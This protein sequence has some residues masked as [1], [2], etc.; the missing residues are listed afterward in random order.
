MAEPSVS[1]VIPVYKNAGTVRELSSRLRS[2]LEGAG[3]TDYEVLFVDDAGPDDSLSV[4]DSL[5]AE[6]PRISVIVLAQNVG[7]QRAVLEG[8]KLALG[9]KAVVLDA[10]LQDAPEA[11]PVL[12]AGLDEGVEAVF[13]G[14]RGAYESRLR[15]LTSKIF[16]RLLGYITGVPA[17][18]GIF[19]AVSRR[20]IDALLEFDE[21]RPFVVALIGRT[22]MPSISIPVERTKRPGGESA[23]SSWARIKI[24]CRA[25]SRAL[26]WK[27][28]ERF[29]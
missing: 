13:A 10:D 1:I 2:T 14:R 22:K 9:S 17:D 27:W 4:L 18:A 26:A 25:V 28:E 21:A 19:V 23:Y 12:L 15:L 16:K 11:I 20:M 24:G 5:A 8:L 3:Y 29:K 6:D 7:Q